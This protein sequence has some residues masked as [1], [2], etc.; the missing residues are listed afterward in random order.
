MCYIAGTT[1]FDH[2]NYILCIRQVSWKQVYF[3]L[4]VFST[5]CIFSKNLYLYQ[6]TRN[7]TELEMKTAQMKMFGYVS[8][9]R[10]TEL[11]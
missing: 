10:K 5:N 6:K 7:P 2:Y 8:S 1:D 3:I 9:C 11:R 4:K